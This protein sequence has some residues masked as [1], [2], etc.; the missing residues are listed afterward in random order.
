MGL[1]T[2]LTVGT[3]LKWHNPALRAT[4]GI[5]DSMCHPCS[6]ATP[7]CDSAKTVHLS[8]PCVLGSAEGCGGFS[9]AC[10]TLQ[11][12]AQV[13]AEDDRFRREMDP[14]A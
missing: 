4:P 5:A 12:C 7:L 13:T 14:G 6:V 1:S 10:R 8:F 3:A 9:S 11:Q 2:S